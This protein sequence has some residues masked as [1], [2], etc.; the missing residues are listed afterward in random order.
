MRDQ[1]SIK[2]L[3]EDIPVSC[4]DVDILALNFL[5]DNP[6]VFSCTYGLRGFAELPQ[7][8]QQ[9]KIYKRLL[10]E[11]SVKNLRPHIKRHGG[12]ME[13]ILVRLDTME[14]IEG[15]SR[16]AVFRDLH[17]RAEGAEREKWEKIPCEIISSLTDRQQFAFL[18]LIHVRG[19]TAWSAYEKANFAFVRH[20]DGNMTI[21]EIADIFGETAR[22]IQKRIDVITKMK[23][24]QDIELSHFS[25]YDVMVRTRKIADGISE[26]EGLE[27]IL[28]KK[29]KALRKQDEE[30]VEF[31]AQELRTKLPQIIP[32]P[33]ILKRFLTGNA[34][35]DDCYQDA[36]ESNARAI[37][38]R[39]LDRLR[40][41]T[42]KELKNLERTELNA[43]AP[44]VRRLKREA[45]RVHKIVQEVKDQ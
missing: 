3:G 21:N 27:K 44:E 42:K 5:L 8:A 17:E 7:E 25:Y 19:K 29:I 30:E 26:N 34:G 4:D 39:V 45:E 36:R 38:K 31:T 15:N 24:N 18:N 9:G 16:L 35:L 43:L 10:E 37:V 1:R 41:V 6:R 40:D 22:E 14:V 13:P 28:N 12:L 20:A 32:K 11:P 33:K 2:I 23:E